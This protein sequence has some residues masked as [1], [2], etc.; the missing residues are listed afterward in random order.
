MF[1]CLRRQ[2]RQDWPVAC[3]PITLARLIAYKPRPGVFCNRE[4][5]GC[6][7]HTAIGVPSLHSILMRTPEP[8]CSLGLAAHRFDAVLTQDQAAMTLLSTWSYLSTR[9]RSQYLKIDTYP[10][11][12]GI[13]FEVIITVLFQMS[14]NALVSPEAPKLVWELREENPSKSTPTTSFP[15]RRS[16]VNRSKP[17]SVLI[18]FSKYAS[19]NSRKKICRRLGINYSYSA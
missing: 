15:K 4:P 10:T 11:F 12:N 8:D 7:K 18:C 19:L 5:C 13:L 9:S 17:D 1:L 3:N 2:A 6:C 16:P 14:S